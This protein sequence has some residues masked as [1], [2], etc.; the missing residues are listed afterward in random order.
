MPLRV[1]VCHWSRMRPV[2]SRSGRDFRRNE[3][4]FAV[5]GKKSAVV[6]KPLLRLGF[7]GARRPQHRRQR[8]EPV[9]RQRL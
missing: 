6:E 9:I 2:F 1:M 7:V 8:V 5:V 3:A 4:G